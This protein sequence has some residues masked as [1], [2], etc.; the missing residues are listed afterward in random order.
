MPRLVGT[1][2]AKELIFTARKINSHVAHE[3]GIVQ[4]VVDA[5]K[6]EEKGL[7]IAREICRN[8]PLAVRAAK[9]S[10]VSGTDVPLKEGMDI[11]RTCY[12]SIIPTSDRLE[13][14]ASFREKRNPTYKGE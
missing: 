8:G 12:Q 7:S 9:K 10:I 14:L 5:G 11:E 3:Y 4:H 2:R 13:G 1:A 6:A